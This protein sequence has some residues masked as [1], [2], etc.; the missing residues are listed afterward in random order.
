VKDSGG[1]TGV[2]TPEESANTPADHDREAD[3]VGR[4]GSD[5]GDTNP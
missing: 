3:V 5:V 1:T 2:K 4:E